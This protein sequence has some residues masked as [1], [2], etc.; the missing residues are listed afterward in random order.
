MAEDNMPDFLKE[1]RDRITSEET[2]NKL[3]AERDALLNRIRDFYKTNLKYRK[4]ESEE[5]TKI[6]EQEERRIKQ[7][8]K[9]KE[10][11]LKSIADVQRELKNDQEKLKIDKAETEAKLKLAVLD[12]DRSAEANKLKII[13]EQ[14]AKLQERQ[15][16]LEES[17][18]LKANKFLLMLNGQKKL[19]SDV[20]EKQEKALQNAKD[21]YDDVLKDPAATDEDVAVAKS[22][23]QAALN[24]NELIS[25]LGTILN[26]FTSILKSTLSSMDSRIKDAVSTYS[27]YMGKVDARLQTLTDSAVTFDTIKSHFG[28]A[29]IA[30]PFMD[31]KSYV[32]NIDKLSAGGILYNIEERAFLETVSDKIVASFDVLD[33]SLLRMTRLQQADMTRYMLGNEALLTRLFNEFFED[34]SYLATNVSDNISAS[35]FEAASTMN[36]A[37]A[38]AFEFTI[39]KWL[40]ALYE[41]GVSQETVSS[42]ASAINALGSGNA[43]DFMNSPVA[44]LLNMAV[45]RGDY[46][47]ADVLTQGINTDFVNDLMNSMI[48]LLKDIKDNTSNQVTLQAYS[49]VMGLSMS[50]IRGFT[51]LKEDDIARL[52]GYEQDLEQANTEVTS[53]LGKIASRTSTAE[54]VDNILNNYLF[55]RGTALAGD[56]TAYAAYLIGDLVEDLAQGTLVG[57]AGSL[58]K[59]V[60]LMVAKDSSSYSSTSDEEE[61]NTSSSLIT[62]LNNLKKTLNAAFNGDSLLTLSSFLRGIPNVK[63][64]RGASFF[65]VSPDYGS[66]Y[67][68]VTSGVSNSA[69]VSSTENNYN[70]QVTGDV[71]TTSTTQQ[72]IANLTT[73]EQTTRQY[74]ISEESAEAYKN[75]MTDTDFYQELLNEQQHPIKIHYDEPTEELLK[76]WYKLTSDIYARQH[77]THVTNTVEVN[78]SVEVSGTVS[79]PEMNNLRSAFDAM[80]WR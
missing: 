27:N 7:E 69:S 25:G 52:S 9:L 34:S 13:N 68:N 74:A 4:V 41:V 32:E 22:K 46:S 5:L 2:I 44:T 42:I 37:A 61:T 57:L 23:Y 24:K 1:Y 33:A 67:N 63:D 20:V 47:I 76:A 79:V 51:N 78:G 14:L 29:Y 73:N 54:I 26:N 12:K 70:S 59:V 35:V 15:L 19:F 43:Q 65:G 8:Y 16:K 11:R 30:S 6:Y 49:R 21:A 77:D 36:Q 10:L 58:D 66:Y 3:T 31:L 75:M 55:K 18:E 45:A 80:R 28:S 39:Q 71:V 40:G 72:R 62:N 50:D 64:S 56:Q 48:T 38:S 53:Q 60:S 17:K